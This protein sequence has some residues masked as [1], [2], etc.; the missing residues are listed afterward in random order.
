MNEA[1]RAALAWDSRNGEWSLQII[2][3]EWTASPMVVSWPAT[4]GPPSLLERYDALAG[5][6][7]AVVEGGPQAWEWTE[8][9]DD[10]GAPLLVGY[11]AVRPLR[12]DELPAD[13]R[14]TT[15]EGRP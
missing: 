11:T 9:M 5:L 13:G 1:T 10:Q 8:A 12:G 15:G 7:F 14:A 6:G 3:P 4:S 2:R